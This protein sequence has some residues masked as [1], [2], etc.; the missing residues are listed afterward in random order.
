MS[1]ERNHATGTECGSASAAGSRGLARPE[2]QWSYASAVMWTGLNECRKSSSIFNRPISKPLKFWR[3]FVTSISFTSCER[4][5]RPAPQSRSEL[6][7][8]HFAGTRFPDGW[9]AMVIPVC[10]GRSKAEQGETMHSVA[11]SRCAQKEKHRR[12]DDGRPVAADEHGLVI[13]YALTTSTS[14]ESRKL[15]FDRPVNLINP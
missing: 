14:S 13:G 1:S 4:R 3:R 15:S 6:G 12:R 7:S 10:T 8:E 9:A 2:N 5:S 11:I